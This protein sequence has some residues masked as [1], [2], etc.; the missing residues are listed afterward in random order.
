MDFCRSSET[1]RKGKIPNQVIKKIQVYKQNNMV[2]TCPKNGRQ[3][4]AQVDATRNGKE[5][6]TKH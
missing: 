1:S 5:R 2:W 4:M 6:K 3:Q